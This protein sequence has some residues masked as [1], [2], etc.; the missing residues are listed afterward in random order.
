MNLRL[1]LRAVRGRLR[2]SSS[3]GRGTKV[4]ALMPLE[5]VERE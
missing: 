4:E 5:E 2:V 1:R 3:P